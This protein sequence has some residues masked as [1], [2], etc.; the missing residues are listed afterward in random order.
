M[1]AIAA[2]AGPPRRV[3]LENGVF[4]VIA[5]DCAAG[6][7]NVTQFSLAAA[8]VFVTGDKT[9]RSKLNSASA[10]PAPVAPS[11]PPRPENRRARPI[12]SDRARSGALSGLVWPAHARAPGLAR[13]ERGSFF[14]L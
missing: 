7:R 10:M 3:L 4:G 11:L 5:V 6:E 12:P 13:S 14:I 1:A 9:L 8:V 2:A